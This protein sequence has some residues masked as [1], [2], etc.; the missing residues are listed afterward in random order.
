MVRVADEQTTDE[1]TTDEY[2]AYSSALQH[3]EPI[4]VGHVQL[5]AASDVAVAVTVTVAGA[6][7]V[8][9]SELWLDVGHV[10]LLIRP[11]CSVY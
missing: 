11:C 6:R 2:T 9:V 8:D 10:Q 4:D 1:Q 5:L 3:V 7:A